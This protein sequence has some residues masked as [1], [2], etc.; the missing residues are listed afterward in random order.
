MTLEVFPGTLLDS[1]KSGPSG[2]LR[3]ESRVTNPATHSREASR[4]SFP[5]G[6]RGLLMLW[7]SSDQPQELS[8]Q[9]AIDVN[10]TYAGFWPRKRRMNHG[11]RG[12]ILTDEVFL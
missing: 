12:D 5:P 10:E 3:S 2:D 11:F 6:G 4:R 9:I 1:G 8:Q 7:P